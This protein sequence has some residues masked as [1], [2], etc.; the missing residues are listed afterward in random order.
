MS[1]FI[2]VTITDDKHSYAKEKIRKICEEHNSTPLYSF[3]LQCNSFPYI[4]MVDDNSAQSGH[5]VS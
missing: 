1:S 2:I 4:L 5:I 3:P